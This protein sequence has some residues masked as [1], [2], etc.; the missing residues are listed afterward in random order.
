MRKAAAAG[1]INAT[2]CADYLAKKGIP[3]RAAYATTG[4]IVAYCTKNGKTLEEMTL[5]EYKSFDNNFE[6]DIFDAVNLENGVT[7]RVS[8]GCASGNSVEEQIKF[9]TEK[10]NNG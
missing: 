2:D 3:F 5:E 7:R 6:E 1:F 9:I 4:E 10:I 8:L